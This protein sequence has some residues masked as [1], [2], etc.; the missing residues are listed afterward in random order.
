MKDIP[1]P[2]VEKD[3][4]IQRKYNSLKRFISYYYQLSTIQDLDPET[5]LEIGSGVN[6]VADL[7]K[8][9]GVSV[10]VSDIDPQVQPDILAD[11]RDLPCEDSSF[12]MVVAFQILEHLPF[13][14]F[15][16]ALGELHRVSNKHVVISLP[17]KSTGFEMVFSHPLIRSI[18]RKD[19]F[20]I[21][22]R[23]PLKFHGFEKSGQHY[24]EIDSRSF[25]LRKIE[26]ILNKKFLIKKSFSP[27]LNKFHYF[28]I[29]EKK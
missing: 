9:S 12:D 13:E 24:W 17:Y 27:V 7:L 18:F 3:Y 6:I 11:V 28:F 2:Q 29:L 1:S 22:I 23:M 5:V 26:K 20:D 10:K 8:K 21:S 14:D 25:R 16:K 15:E 4:Y 19:F